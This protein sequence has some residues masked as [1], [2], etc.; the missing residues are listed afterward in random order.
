MKIKKQFMPDMK[1]DVYRGLVK[2]VTYQLV[3]PMTANRE[4]HDTL[5]GIVNAMADTPAKLI[6]L[7]VQLMYTSRDPRADDGHAI[8]G[9][10]A[11]AARRHARHVGILG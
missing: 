9:Q 1:E 8:C 10:S 2:A 7:A 11:R 3:G 6:Y 5:M 4:Q